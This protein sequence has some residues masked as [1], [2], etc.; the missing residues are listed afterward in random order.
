MRKP[1]RSGPIWRRVNSRRN[2]S[3]ALS[4]DRLDWSNW[5]TDRL[6]VLATDIIQ[7]DVTTSAKDA[8]KHFA[9]LH[10]VA[11]DKTVHRVFC[12]HAD[13]PRLGFRNGKLYWLI[14]KKQTTRRI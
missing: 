4:L 13:N 8:V 2:S 6:Q 11:D 3:C 7:D 14:D 1:K 12:K 10:V 5:W 9:Y